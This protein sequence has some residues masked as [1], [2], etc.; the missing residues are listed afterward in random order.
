MQ[1]RAPT[2]L[3][4]LEA[5]YLLAALALAGIHLY[6]AVLAPAVPA[7]RTSPFLAIGLLLLLG[8]LLF[9]T[10]AWRPLLYLIGALLALSL[11][12]VWALEGMS[13]PRV[14]IAAGLA[15]TVLLFVGAYLFVR[16]EW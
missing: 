14:G 10:S 1:F 4:A 9:F 13:Y 8:P 12:V 15:A 2:D 11:G 3:D 5:A 6:L 16:A 7:A